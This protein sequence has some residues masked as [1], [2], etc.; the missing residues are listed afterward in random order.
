MHE[1]NCKIGMH[2]KVIYNVVNNTHKNKS[3]EK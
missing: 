3:M 2:N 1:E